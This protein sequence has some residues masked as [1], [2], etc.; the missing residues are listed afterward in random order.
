MNENSYDGNWL[1]DKRNGQGTFKWAS[2]NTYKGNYK[3][4][5][6]DGKGLFIWVNEEKYDGD[7]K[8]DARNGV[9]TYTW[10]NGS[11]YEG[12]FKDNER[13][14]QGTYT[15]PAGFSISNC[16]YCTKYTGKWLNNRK[17]A[18]GKCYNSMGVLIFDGYFTDDKPWGNYPQNKSN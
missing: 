10:P 7:W 2:G 8:E 13:S 15:V 16:P 4:D 17:V 12:E 11:K 3:D 1:N 14:G 18:T 5:M 9:G 6:R